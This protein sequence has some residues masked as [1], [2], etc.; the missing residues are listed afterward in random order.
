MPLYEKSAKGILYL[1]I[2]VDDNVMVGKPKLIDEAMGALQ[3]LW[4]SI[5]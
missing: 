2:Y 3:K 4:A 5:Y 1:D